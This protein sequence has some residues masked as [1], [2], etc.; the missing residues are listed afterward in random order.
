MYI[1]VSWND[2][3]VKVWDVQVLVLDI[4]LNIYLKYYFFLDYVV[5]YFNFEYICVNEVMEYCEKQV[6]DVCCVIMVVGN[7]VVGKLEIDEYVLYIVDLV[8]VIVFNIQEWMLLIVFNNGVIYNF[9][10]EVMVEILC[11]V[12]YNGLELLVVGDILQFQKG[13]MSQ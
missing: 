11:L 1:E 5:Q 9:D 13:L 10:D 2:I 6:F 7:L 8:V 12:G 4:L 3:Y